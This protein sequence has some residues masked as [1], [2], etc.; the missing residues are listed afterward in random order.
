MPSALVAASRSNLNRPGTK[1]K[2][3]LGIFVS[4]WHAPA[5]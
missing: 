4:Q 5:L 1:A 3:L 2:H